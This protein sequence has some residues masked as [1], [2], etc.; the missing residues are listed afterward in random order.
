MPDDLKEWARPL[1]EDSRPPVARHRIQEI[2]TSLGD[3]GKRLAGGDP[4]AFAH[5]VIATRNYLVRGKSSRMVL[6]DAE[7]RFRHANALSWIGIAYLLSR[8]GMSG[9]A[10]SNAFQ[11]NRWATRVIEQM[12]ESNEEEDPE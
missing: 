4:E 6:H 8:L 12:N 5:R 7:A 1:L 11:R 2:I 10:V 3:V 9:E